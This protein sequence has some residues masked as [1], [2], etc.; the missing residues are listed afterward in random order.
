M[1]LDYKYVLSAP[2]NA[3]TED[4]LDLPVNPEG[5]D[6]IDYSFVRSEKNGVFH[7]IV[8]DLRFVKEGRD[9]LI[10]KV[11][12]DGIHAQTICTI[13]KKNKDTNEYEFFYQGR[14]DYSGATE[15]KKYFICN[16]EAEGF[17]QTF[18]NSTK[19]SFNIETY[20]DSSQVEQPS[21]T[22]TL[23]QP[24]TIQK[25]Y[26][27]KNDIAIYNELLNTSIRATNYDV[28]YFPLSVPITNTSEIEAFS[29]PIFLKDTSLID[30]SQFLIS[31][32]EEGTYTFDIDV[33]CQFYKADNGNS[34]TS[35]DYQL[36]RVEG[37]TYTTLDTVTI[38]FIDQRNIPLSGT[39]AD[40]FKLT[41]GK[42][43]ASLSLNIGDEVY[44]QGAATYSSTQVFQLSHYIRN[45][46]SP[47]LSTVNIVADTTFAET[48]VG[49]V[50]IYEALLSVAQKITGQTDVLRSDFFGRTDSPDVYVSDG[51]GSLGVFVDGNRLRGINDKVLSVSWESL[52][53]CLH[54]IYGIGW[55][56]EQEQFQQVIRVEQTAFFYE[57]AQSVDLLASFNLGKT[58]QLQYFEDVEK[59]PNEELYY[60]S[61][62]FQY[63]KLEAKSVNGID[64]FNTSREFN[65]PV[66]ELE[67]TYLLK[68]EIRASGYETELQR[69]KAQEPTT[70]TKIDDDIFI[71]AVIRN[72]LTFQNEQ[73]ETFTATNL[74]APTDAY[75]LRYAPT[76]SIR[77][78]GN[79]INSSLLGTSDNIDFAAGELNYLMTT[80]E[81]VSTVIAENGDIDKDEL[82]FPILY[83]EV[84]SLEIALLNSDIQIIK[85]NPLQ[86]I[87][88]TIL[89][90]NVF[91][92]IN[93]HI[94]K[95]ELVQAGEYKDLFKFTL[96][97]RFEFETPLP[98]F[99]FDLVLGFANSNDACNTVTAPTTVF[100]D[101]PIL[102]VGSLL[103]STSG[104][105]S[106][107][108][109]DQ[110]I[111]YSD[112]DVSFDLA[113]ADGTITTI[114]AC[115]LPTKTASY[116]FTATIVGFVKDNTTS[117][118][119]EGNNED[120]TNTTGIN[121][122][123][124]GTAVITTYVISSG[125]SNELN[126]LGKE[127]KLSVSVYNGT[128]D[129][130][131]QIGTTLTAQS[132]A[133]TTLTPGTINISNGDI[134]TNLFVKVTLETV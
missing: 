134:T 91:K 52:I 79:W 1:S 133:T 13:H 31:I 93:G 63:P 73:D 58:K 17:Q 36:I 67:N 21:F 61:I 89:K 15:T 95:I 47:V 129:S 131:P 57:N 59:S 101:S 71:T 97:R 88:F 44:I 20:I 6:E 8:T 70:D 29:Y 106:S 27:G 41:G 103:Y 12:T 99:S 72:G 87:S 102:L 96:L 69:R 66:K 124:D 28:L 23:Y 116:N 19:K 40:Y 83:P 92:Q 9:Y 117:C 121:I 78:H 45:D 16:L 114:T 37:S 48:T 94:R 82:E 75:N 54:S 68:S 62:K 53:D 110:F 60:S 30:D 130:D 35:L 2:D 42:L 74:I 22:D 80:Q 18:L 86:F 34:I 56:V 119:I 76:R 25:E 55:T 77:R 90:D 84:Y 10:D 65:T 125:D 104:N 98:E 127:L 85:N 39:L 105:Q 122:G 126:M 49:T 11:D 118:I 109:S 111:Y 132:D 7:D 4:A 5:F 51:D 112:N 33:E 64:E 115:P 38:P 123:S 81:G 108:L 26:E 24:K 128:S 43:S 120:E 50:P 113:S 3:T 107:F 100:S 14:V 32:S 46:N